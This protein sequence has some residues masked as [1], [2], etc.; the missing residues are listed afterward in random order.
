MNRYR[1]KLK[2]GRVIGPFVIDQIS[3]LLNSQHI[4]GTE[5]FQTFPNGDW[6]RMDSFKEFAGLV[7][8]NE[9]EA[10]FIKKIGDLGESKKIEDQVQLKNE[11]QNDSDF[12]KEFEFSKNSKTETEIKITKSRNEEKTLIR[13]KPQALQVEK[14]DKTVINA[15]IAKQL[16]EEQI[17]SQKN[18]ENEENEDIEEVKIDKKPI[19]LENEATQML[20]L[21]ELNKVVKKEAQ[22]S[23]SEL[24][25]KLDEIKGRDRASLENEEAEIKSLLFSKNRIKK[26]LSDKKKRKK[27][28]YFVLVL[29]LLFV[30]FDDDS[31]K[32]SSAGLK[33][34]FPEISFPVQYENEN[35]TKA[36]ELFQQGEQLFNENNYLAK[37]KASKAFKN[38]L[39]NSFNNNPALSSYILSA[40]Y[41]LGHIPNAQ[42]PG[43]KI[44]KLIELS[45]NKYLEDV[46]LAT[47]IALF[48]Y[49]LEKY[50]ASIGVIEKYLS[51]T[52]PSLL[53]FSV[54][55]AA[56]RESGD[57]V[58]ARS[59]YE[60]V[61]AQT[62]KPLEIYL[63]TIKFDFLNE[64]YVEVGLTL[65]EALQLFPTSAP[66]LLQQARLEL[67]QNNYTALEKTL[68]LIKQNNAEN[69]PVY[70]A[71]YLEYEALLFVSQ[72][73]I[74]SAVKNFQNAL[75]I[76]DSPDLRSKLGVLQSDVA[77]PEVSN[78]ILKSKTIDLMNKAKHALK[79]GDLNSAQNFAINA[80]DVSN[81]YLPAKVLL[82]RIQIQKGYF[83]VALQTLEDLVKANPSEPLSSFALLEAYTESFKFSRALAHLGLISNSN[84]QQHQD[85]PENV[86]KVFLKTKDYLQAIN[87]L[88]KAINNKPLNEE[89]YYLLGKVFL[90]QKNFTNAKSML[91]R[92]IELNP[93]EASFRVAYSNVLYEMENVDTA[94]GYLRDISTK[95]NEDPEVQSQIAIYYYRSGQLAQFEQQKAKLES[96]PRKTTKLYKFLI[97]VVLI[98]EKFDQVIDY[99]Q[100]LLA[101]N[102]GDLETRMLLGRI[103]FEKEKYAESLEQF[104]QVKER[105]DTYPKLLY[106]IS[107]IYLM[108]GQTEKAIDLANQELE[109]NPGL[110][111]TYVLLG[112]IYRDMKKYVEAEK[113]YKEGQKRNQNS[114]DAIMGLAFISSKKNQYE[115]A[116]DLYKKA[117]SQEPNNAIIH[118]NL[119]DT[120][121]NLGQGKLAVESYKVFLELEPE[122]KYKA[123]IEKYIRLLK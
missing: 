90:S 96:A 121:R 60:K 80:V 17:K 78:L 101:L 61:K 98:D 89:N 75:A 46:K 107:K 92:A 19:D 86:A 112:D 7:D 108:T 1:I 73:N 113:Y 41:L 82:S 16:K 118:K 49:N 74:S 69:S 2:S 39:E 62:N 34:I 115:V 64:N 36:Q 55:L 18:K 32:N 87:W 4:D 23:E 11:K 120:Y 40:S 3:E 88:T 95:F 104:K 67:Y 6:L 42:I 31:D 84:L 76:N 30:L 77:S 21:A 117:S 66:L 29:L 111:S 85:Y 105:L 35:Q 15:E 106:Y 45:K 37:L 12:P 102:P 24:K 72:K 5:F 65:K 99:G 44:F 79:K 14:L 63:E 94:L 56:L 22:E 9:K 48:Y 53:M 13:E 116:L 97:D 71:K 38:S 54:Y 25:Q 26:T 28:L 47:G 52:N 20:D 70:I 83:K 123:E 109:A 27:I 33:P 93:Q 59:V 100:K 43:N 68:S 51:V 91:S 110:D 81:S 57:L 103:L 122:T 114:I 58:K 8:K 10:T 119:G 50:Y